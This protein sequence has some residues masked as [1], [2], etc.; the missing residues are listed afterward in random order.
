MNRRNFL[1]NTSL[2]ALAVGS[3]SSLTSCSGPIQKFGY[4]GRRLVIVKLDGGNDGLFTILP[5][6]FD[7]IDS[8][9]PNLSRAAKKDGIPVFGDWVLNTSF[10]QLRDLLPPD[11]LS[12]LP[13]VGYPKPNTSHF[14]S[15]EIWETGALLGNKKGK[16]GW[17]GD[18]LDSGK[19]SLP[20]NDIPVLSLTEIETLVFRSKITYGPVWLGND[21]LDYY[22]SYISDWLNRFPDNQVQRKLISHY[23]LLHSLSKLNK[24]DN[25]P[26]TDLG[27]QLSRVA[28]IINEERPYKVFFT[29]QNG[30]DTHSHAVE[31]LNILY[32]DLSSSLVSFVKSLK[33]SNNW[34][35]TLVLIFSEFGRTIDENASLGTDHGTASLCLLL[36][37]NDIVRRYS[38]FIPKIEIVNQADEAYLA[39]Q[40]DFRQ[41]YLDI[42]NEWLLIE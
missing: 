17:L 22:H 16:T 35:N 8:V 32:K 36:G 42:Q 6:E 10:S 29:S 18:I 21:S 14:K 12:I 13:F 4:R 15:T 19:L 33:S 24:S 7:P 28:S 9:R 25:F 3:G 20:E 5:R 39:H 30:Y 40:I 38:G 37:D 1:I 41:L 26:S 34:G 2:S 31:R 23:N 27:L 11:E